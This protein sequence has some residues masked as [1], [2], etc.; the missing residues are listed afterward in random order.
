MAWLGLR[1][2]LFSKG[3]GAL[4][5]RLHLHVAELGYAE[6]QMLAS[7]VTLVG[8]ALQQELGELKPSEGNL[9]PIANFRRQLHRGLVVDQGFLRLLQKRRSPTQVAGDAG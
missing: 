1:G 3:K 8:I 9:G 2:R 5:G 6:L 4:E 7:L